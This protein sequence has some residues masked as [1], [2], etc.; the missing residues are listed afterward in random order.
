MLA[1]GNNALI[2]L[3]LVIGLVLHGAMYAP[4]GGVHHR[5]VPDPDPLFGRLDRLSA[6][7][8]LRRLARADHRAVA[9]QGPALGGAGLD[10][11]RHRLRDQRRQRAA[12]AGD[13]GRGAWEHPMI[14]SFLL[15]GLATSLPASAEG[16]IKHRLNVT[17]YKSAVADLN[18]DGSSEV[19]VYSTERDE[20][21][22]G[23]C[24]LSS[25]ATLGHVPRHDGIERNAVARA[26]ARNEDPWLAGYWG[27]G[28]RRE[29][30]ALHGANAFQ[31]RRYPS[32]P[33]VPPA[34]PM[35]RP[36]GECSIRR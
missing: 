13:E 1:S 36:Y 15:A 7:R 23:G 16:F 28:R 20:C 12:G 35:R 3:A 22:S 17:T 29:F 10:L 33:T 31:R 32:N 5:A 27:D 11:R 8:D 21:G 25:L 9:V 6:D 19:F 4:A 2:I 30:Y 24:N 14:G 34:I 26:S 18:G